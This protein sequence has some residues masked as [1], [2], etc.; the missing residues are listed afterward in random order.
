MSNDL[1]LCLHWCSTSA[2]HLDAFVFISDE[3]VRV[4]GRTC[5]DM[6][7][8]KWNISLCEALNINI[9]L[10]FCRRYGTLPTRGDIIM[11]KNVSVIMFALSIIVI[12]G[13]IE[14]TVDVI[15]EYNHISSLPNTSGIDYLGILIYP[16]LYCITAL[17]GII[18]SAVC[19]K[20]STDKTIKIISC[21]L[22]GIFLVVC[23]IFGV[24]WF[25]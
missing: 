18:T 9:I 24:V 16:F 17:C 15:A 21:V 11:R 4:F 20:L 13:L 3:C 23:C 10:N 8:G 6:D 1:P 12:I 19:L 25:T 14:L 5:V 7:K 22:L 2:M